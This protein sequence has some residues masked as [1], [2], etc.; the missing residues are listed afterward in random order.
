MRV[1]I[2]SADLM[3]RNLDHRVECITEIVDEGLKDRLDE[4]LRVNLEDDVLAW[5]LGP[6]GWSKVRTR[7]GVESQLVFRRL[8]EGR[9][10][11]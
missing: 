11:G 1:F 8:A 2:G 10:L 7:D 4:I 9:A 5:S 6:D 3:P